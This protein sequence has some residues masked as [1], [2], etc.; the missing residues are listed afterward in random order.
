MN[1]PNWTFIAHVMVHLISIIVIAYA[2]NC[3]CLGFGT[4]FQ[5]GKEVIWTSVLHENCIRSCEFDARILN[6][7]NW[8]SITQVMTRFSKLPQATLFWPNL[9]SRFLGLIFGL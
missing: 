8:T 1:H 2:V 3:L 9:L 7:P 5:L 4:D 6:H